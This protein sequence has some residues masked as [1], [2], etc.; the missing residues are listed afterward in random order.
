MIPIGVLPEVVEV[1]VHVVNAVTHGGMLTRIQRGPV[2]AE[3]EDDC[4]LHQLGSHGGAF[5]SCLKHYLSIII[6]T[7]ST[8]SH[9]T[10]TKS[11]PYESIKI[12]RMLVSCYPSEDNAGTQGRRS[13]LAIKIPL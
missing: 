9:Q 5:Q 11:L 12:I 10:T 6:T 2:I 13:N 4:P 3:T 8:Y 1:D 7:S